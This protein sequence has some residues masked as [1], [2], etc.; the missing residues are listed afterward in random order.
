MSS[1]IT[2]LETSTERTSETLTK[3]VSSLLNSSKKAFETAVEILQV[4]QTA[5]KNSLDG[6]QQ[7]VEAFKGQGDRL[8]DLD[9]KL[10]AAFE[11]YADHVV[12]SLARMSTHTQDLVNQLSPALDTMREVVEQAEQF[13]P[14]STIAA[15]K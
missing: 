9:E 5:L 4:E 1:S 11:N 6:M 15:R 7:I 14:E 2:K 10:G 12:G 13:I 3:G 8:D